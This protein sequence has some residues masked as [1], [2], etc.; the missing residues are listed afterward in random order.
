MQRSSP[1]LLVYFSTIPVL[2]ADRTNSISSL[3]FFSWVL[4]IFTAVVALRSR[5]TPYNIIT[6]FSSFF[7]DDWE[8]KKQ[9]GRGL[10]VP[11]PFTDILNPIGWDSLLSCLLRVGIKNDARRRIGM[12]W[13][14]W[15]RMYR[16][17][18]L[19]GV[20][21]FVF[22]FS[23]LAFSFGI[24]TGQDGPRKKTFSTA[25]VMFKHKTWWLKK[26]KTKKNNTLAILRMRLSN[27]HS[28][29][30]V[31]YYYCALSKS[32]AVFQ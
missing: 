17:L 24:C 13:N 23:F 7:P 15:F 27:N 4:S 28:A 2:F 14:R 18:G 9:F 11:C 5:E 8:R 21:V 16:Q 3:S 22:K 6:I 30:S 32:P 12:S 10:F 1:I 25:A 20:F 19:L 29:C 31:L 26:T